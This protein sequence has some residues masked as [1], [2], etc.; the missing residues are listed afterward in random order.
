MPNAGERITALETHVAELRDTI[1]DIRLGSVPGALAT[2]AAGPVEC[3]R[4][5]DGS[6]GCG[7]GHTGTWA[8]DMRQGK[9]VRLEFEEYDL[10]PPVRWLPSS[11]PGQLAFFAQNKELL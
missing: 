9:H 4:R 7:Q 8:N 10:L 11:S 2:L 6:C 5:D 3:R 1:T